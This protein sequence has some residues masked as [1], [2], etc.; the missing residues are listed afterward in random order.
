MR[1]ARSAGIR[2]RQGSRWADDL[3]EAGRLDQQFAELIEVVWACERRWTLEN[4]IEA[5][6]RCGRESLHSESQRIASRFAKRSGNEQ[7]ATKGPKSI[8]PRR[9]LRDYG[10]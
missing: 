9:K 6:I 4:R 3:T 10:W 1:Q 8:T 7:A 2:N 5:S